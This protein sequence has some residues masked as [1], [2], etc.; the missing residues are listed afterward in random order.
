VDQAT[1]KGLP[2]YARIHRKVIYVLVVLALAFPIMCNISMPPAPL[3]AAKAIFERVERI[4]RDRSSG[5]GDAAKVVL[6][7]VDWGPHTRAECY[8]QTEAVVRHLMSRGIPFI[9]LTTVVDGAGY[10]REIPNK[11]AREYGRTYGEDWVDL[12]YK[13]GRSVFIR[14]IARDLKGAAKVD[15]DGVPLDSLTVTKDVKDAGDVVLLVEMTGLVGFFNMWVQF[16][17]TDRARPDFAH[18]CTS[19]TI[20]EAY[21]Y[22]E[23]GQIVGLFEGIAGAAAYNELLEKSRKTG[24]PHA[25]ADARLHMTAQSF[26]HLVIIV[27][28]ILGNFGL[29]VRRK[30]GAAS[31]VTGGNP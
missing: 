23:S 4:A 7:A 14:Q 9:I 13:P 18:G 12:G 2:W 3:P 17:Q 31:G 16:F 6:V 29:S 11:V 5:D 1:H 10:A 27:L 28:I 20:A 22:L 19:V 21:T 30:A 26:A 24:E 8:P 25:S 15:R